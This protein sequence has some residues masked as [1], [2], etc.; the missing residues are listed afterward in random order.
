MSLPNAYSVVRVHVAH[1]HRIDATHSAFTVADGSRYLVW[2][3]QVLFD[4]GIIST[5]SLTALLSFIYS[6]LIHACSALS[7]VG[8]SW[9]DW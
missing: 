7:D 6:Y 1:H 5:C 9:C 8:M 2:H 4:R 3:A